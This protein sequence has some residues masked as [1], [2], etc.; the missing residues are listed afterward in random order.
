MKF[1]ACSLV[2]AAI[3]VATVVEGVP[4]PTPPAKAF[5]VPVLPSLSSLPCLLEPLMPLD[6]AVVSSP[7]GLPFMVP[8]IPVRKSWLRCVN[9]PSKG[10]ARSISQIT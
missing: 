8:A 2:A 1:F 9:D 4:T 6:T 3:A 5:P 7:T 10:L